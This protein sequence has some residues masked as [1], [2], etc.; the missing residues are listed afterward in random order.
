M[1]VTVGKR[2]S[3]NLL[4]VDLQQIRNITKYSGLGGLVLMTEFGDIS[5]G[6]ED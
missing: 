6:K 2:Q 1:A 3:A 4:G 5:I